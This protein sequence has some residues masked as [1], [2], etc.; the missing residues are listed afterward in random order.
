MV[1]R[2]AGAGFG[3]F[4]AV[5]GAGCDGAAVIGPDGACACIASVA[6]RL[7][8]ANP[9]SAVRLKKWMAFMFVPEFAKLS[10]FEFPQKEKRVP[11]FKWWRFLI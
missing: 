6:R 3:A 2:G 8:A 7:N 11:F 9:A 4:V 10:L 1:E 5:A